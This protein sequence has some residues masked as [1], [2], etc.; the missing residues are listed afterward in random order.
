MTP[1]ADEASPMPAL[2]VLVVDDEAPILELLAGYLRREGWTVDTA[3]DGEAALEAARAASPEVVV[4]DVML[5]GLDGLEVCRHL[6]SFS[7]AVVLMLSARNEAA[8]RDAGL[9]A[10]ADDYLGKPFSPREVVA[11]I[12]ALVGRGEPDPGGVLG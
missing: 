6:R 8:D 5:P 12:R 7:S 10:G 4:L 9:L 3:P 2:R 11:R 1:P